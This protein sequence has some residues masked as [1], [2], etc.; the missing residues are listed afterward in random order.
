GL[1]PVLIGVLLAMSAFVRFRLAGTTV[2]PDRASS[3]LVVRGPYRFTRN[4]M[5][6]GMTL[7]YGGVALA[8]QS[9]WA[10][11]LLPAVLWLIRT[12][13]IAREE[14]FLRERFGD[15]YVE[16]QSRVRRWL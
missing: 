16:Y 9:L 3:A 13:V 12:R 6:L 7:A 10:L 15:A 5:Y 2:R 4:P 1:V 8:A 14:A 11:L